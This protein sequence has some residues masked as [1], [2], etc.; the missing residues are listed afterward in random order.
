LTKQ[1]ILLL[2]AGEFI[3]R[4]VLRGLAAADWATPIAAVDARSPLRDGGVDSRA[5]DLIDT[6]SI[7]AALPGI[8]GIVNCVSGNPG[9]IEASA[10]AL[11]AAA[12]SMPSPPRIVHISSMT[13]YGSA[14]GLVDE[15]TPLR[16][17]LGAYSAA[18][19]A[20][21]TLAADYPRAVILRPGCEFGP[22][23]DYWGG[24]TARLLFAR[25]LGD[26]GPA[27]DGHCNLVDIEDVVAAVLGSLS[28][29]TIPKGAFNLSNPQSSSWND[30]L[31]R[32]AIALRAVPVRR[33]S[34]RR[35]QI[36]SRLLAPPLKVAEIVA[37]R[38]GIDAGRVP[39]PIPSSLVR[40][41]SQGIRLDTRRAEAELRLSWKDLNTTLQQ[42]AR[43]FLNGAVGSR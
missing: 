38:C 36:E 26:L 15:S 43:W 23:S 11:F 24:R 21:E 4:R 6:E 25:R 31:T 41:M 16:G 32:Y 42:T 7:R 22:E 1:T 27:G 12:S 2:G 13:V 30:V 33:I 10:K 28:A 3:G 20:A 37:R 19:V 5:V 35:L 39:A 18:K 34:A 17:D 9:V 29:S 8:A 40:L 14:T